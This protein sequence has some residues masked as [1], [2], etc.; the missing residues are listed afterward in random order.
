MRADYLWRGQDVGES[1]SEADLSRISDWSCSS[2]GKEANF[3]QHGLISLL[4]PILRRPGIKQ[5]NCKLYIAKFKTLLPI[6]SN[7]LVSKRATRHVP[8]PTMVKYHCGARDLWRVRGPSG[9]RVLCTSYAYL[10]R[11][12]HPWGLRRK[13]R[14]MCRSC[15]CPRARGC[16]LIM[17][18]TAGLVCGNW[19]ATTRGARGSTT[20]TFQKSWSCRSSVTSR[21][22]CPEPALLVQCLPPPQWSALLLATLSECLDDGRLNSN[23]LLSSKNPALRTSKS[24]FSPL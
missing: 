23:C 13:G 3:A 18:P 1:R 6:L 7:H 19:T 4:D 2:P 11:R 10:S 24:T 16:S 22:H 9:W 14:K 20:R 21:K 5:L 17:W 12:H 8:H 15:C